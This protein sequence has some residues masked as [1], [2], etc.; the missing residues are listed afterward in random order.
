MKNTIFGRQ[1]MLRN[2]ACLAV[3]CAAT[4]AINT[5]YAEEDSEREK[6]ARISHE[7]QLIRLMVADASKQSEQ[8]GR[9]RFRYDLLSRDIDLIEQ[10]IEDHL[11][12][13]AQP[14]SAPPL[15]GD[16]RN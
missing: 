11:A 15:S 3:A 12:A 1:R 4:L 13:P 5:T 2:F 10:G 16:Y 8:K 6:L 9:V 7:L 14:R